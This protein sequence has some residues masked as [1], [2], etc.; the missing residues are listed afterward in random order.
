MPGR[1][2][3]HDIVDAECVS[4]RDALLALRQC[5]VQ[6]RGA[7]Q[8]D[9]QLEGVLDSVIHVEVLVVGQPTHKVHFVGSFF[10]LGKLSVLLKMALVLRCRERV[11]RLGVVHDVGRVLADDHRSGRVLVVHVLVLGRARVVPVTK[12]GKVD[13]ERGLV[14][15]G[16]FQ[17][18]RLKLDRP[19]LERLELGPLVAEELVDLPREE[20]PLKLVIPERDALYGVKVVR[21]GEHLDVG[22]VQRLLE[23]LRVAVRR[24][25]LVDVVRK[26]AIIIVVAHWDARQDDWAELLRVHV[27]LL[28]GV[29]A[30]QLVVEPLANAAH[31]D[32]TGVLGVAHVQL[33]YGARLALRLDPRVHLADAAE[34]FAK[35]QVDRVDVDRDRY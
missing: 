4:A 30:K 27:P 19:V 8:T 14:H 21:G 17:D 34:V 35:Q 31:A 26:V 7:F 6:E 10:L 5:L 24:E 33:A 12:L 32:L 25:R 20:S 3:R 2:Q 18:H 22:V 23:P 15:A 1:G 11:V 29:L 28:L 16:L 13:H 9:V